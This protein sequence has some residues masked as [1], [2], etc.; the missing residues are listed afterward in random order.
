MHFLAIV[1]V[2]VPHHRS[3][4]TPCRSVCPSDRQSRTRSGL[5]PVPAVHIPVSHSEGSAVNRSAHGIFWLHQHQHSAPDDHNVLYVLHF[6]SAAFILHLLAP[7]MNASTMAFFQ[8]LSYCP[9]QYAFTVTSLNSSL[10][11]H[12]QIPLLSWY[13]HVLQFLL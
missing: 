8:L 4:N 7:L 13:L 11:G 6:F 9:Q 3:C 1:F 2:H 5:L 12:T 10:F